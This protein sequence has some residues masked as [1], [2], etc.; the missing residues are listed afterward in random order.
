MSFRI[1]LF[2][3]SFLVWSESRGMNIPHDGESLK[4]YLKDLGRSAGPM[5]YFNPYYMAFTLEEAEKFPD[6]VSIHSKMR[7]IKSSGNITSTD[8]ESLRIST[9]TVENTEETTHSRVKRDSESK[10]YPQTNV[11]GDCENT[12]GGLVRLCNVCPARTD[13]GPDKIPRYI[14]E[15][16]CE[17][18]D[19]CGVAGVLLGLCE[20]AV[21]V[22]DFLMTQGSS[23]VVYSQEIRV[24]CECGL[25]PI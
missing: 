10:S 24:C 17:S 21:V 8:E 22:Q 23:L 15:V 3:A 2:V 13:L 6:L 11:T 16:L 25:L 19:P 1:L 5:G 18:E 9:D 14:N 4:E 20:S 7:R 12:T